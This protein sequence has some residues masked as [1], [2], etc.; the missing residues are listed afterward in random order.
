[1][2]PL[3]FAGLISGMLTLVATPPNLVVHAELR[4]AGLE[5]FGFSISRPLAWRC[6]CSASATC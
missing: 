2:M 3:A 4:R 5:G 6:W 1:M